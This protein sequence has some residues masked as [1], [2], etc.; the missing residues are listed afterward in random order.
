V[1]ADVIVFCLQCSLQD[2]FCNE[3]A[4]Q[5][6]EA[7]ELACDGVIMDMAYCPVRCVTSVKVLNNVTVLQQTGVNF[8]DNEINKKQPLFRL[9]LTSTLI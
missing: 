7:V 5:D 6:D 9:M 2:V 4:S 8:L 1:T 3:S